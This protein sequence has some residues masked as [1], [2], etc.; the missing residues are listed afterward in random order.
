MGVGLEDTEMKTCYICK[1]QVVPKR[2]EHMARRENLYVLVRELPAE[3]CTQCGE[4]YLDDAA[5]REI[6]AALDRGSD[7]PE[8]LDV[9]IV[10]VG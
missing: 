7:A 9:P 2:I 1:G 4:V 3:V 10:R 5:S 8:H 6:D